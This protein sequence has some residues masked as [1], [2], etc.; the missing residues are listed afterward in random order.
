MPSGTLGTQMKQHEPCRWCRLHAAK[1]RGCMISTA[2]RILD[3]VRLV[4]VNLCRYCN[5]G[6]NA[7]IKDQLD[8]LEH[9]MLAASLHQP[10]VELSERLARLSGLGHCFYGSD[11]AFRHRDCAEDE[12]PLL[13]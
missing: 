10:V 3:A 12:L 4:W 13:A 9:V 2:I 8:Q 6:I 7:A 1:V 5:R 11:G